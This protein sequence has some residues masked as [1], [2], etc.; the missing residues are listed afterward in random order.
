MAGMRRLV[1][2]PRP[3]NSPQ[4]DPGTADARGSPVAVAGEQVELVAE[5]GCQVQ[6]V[7]GQPLRRRY[8]EVLTVTGRHVVVF[9]DTFTGRWF[10][11]KA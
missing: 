7:D 5:T 6:V 4:A 1:S 10:S 3:M 11:Q 8:Y 2:P 9:R